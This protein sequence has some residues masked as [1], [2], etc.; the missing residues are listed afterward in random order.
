MT[1]TPLDYLTPPPPDPSRHSWV[2]AA[3]SLACLAVP[4]VGLLLRIGP[5]FLCGGAI[6]APTGMIFGTIGILRSPDGLGSVSV[7]GTFLNALVFIGLAWL[8]FIEGLC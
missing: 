6:A 3:L 4:C 2:Y 5:V 7:L 8:F 1:P